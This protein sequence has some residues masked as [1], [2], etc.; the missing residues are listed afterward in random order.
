MMHANQ[1]K[2]M[3]RLMELDSARKRHSEKAQFGVFWSYEGRTV[4][5]YERG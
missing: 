2:I 1:E 3:R 4:E 5:K